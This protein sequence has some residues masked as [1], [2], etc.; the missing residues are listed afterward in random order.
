[1]RLEGVSG[2]LQLTPAAHCFAS[3]TQSDAAW[4]D[5]AKITVTIESWTIWD[6]QTAWRRGNADSKACW[7]PR[8]PTSPAST[9]A[10]NA[11]KASR[12]FLV[13]TKRDQL[14]FPLAPTPDT[15]S[16]ARYRSHLS[17]PQSRIARLSRGGLATPYSEQI[18]T[19][20]RARLSCAARDF[21]TASTLRRCFALYS[22]NYVASESSRE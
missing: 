5:L 17:S 7:A 11:S 14:D 6:G 18:T 3:L 9:A 8:R 4:E 22:T 2:E 13:K 16:G 1:M 10:L 20:Y 12:D 21:Q 15:D 19:T